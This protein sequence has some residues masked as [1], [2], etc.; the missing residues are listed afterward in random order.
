MF[1]LKEEMGFEDKEM[2]DLILNK[3]KLLM[4]SMLLDRVSM[5]RDNEKNIN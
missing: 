4:I 5:F 3:P 2:K 1:V